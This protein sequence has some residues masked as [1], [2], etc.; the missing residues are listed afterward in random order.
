MYLYAI[1]K[2]ILVFH[3]A[4]HLAYVRSVRWYVS[5]M[6]RLP[7]V[8]DHG[9][10]QMLTTKSYFTIRRSDKLWSVNLTDQAIEQDLMRIISTRKRHYP[11]TQAKL[12]QIL[13]KCIPI[14]KSRRKCVV[15]S[16]TS[17]QH[18]DL[19]ASTSVCDDF[20]R[21]LTWQ[22]AQSHL[23]SKPPMVS[24]LLPLVWL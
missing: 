21:Y 9:Q 18:F 20:E 17:D 11:S 8:M 10:F 16:Q 1:I 15:H 4:G 7:E 2:M 6:H 5:A 19:P 23:V 14:C 22:K 24:S 13:P 12:V 3:A